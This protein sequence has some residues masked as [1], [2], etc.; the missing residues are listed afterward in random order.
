MIKFQDVTIADKDT[1]QSFTLHGELQNCDLSIANIISWRFLYNTQWAIVNNYLVFRFY[2]N[3]HLAYMLPVPRPTENEDGKLSVK[4]CDA[5]SI[6]VIKALKEDANAL[7]HPFLMLGVCNCMVDV[8]EQFM[9]NTFEMKPN[10]DYADYIYTREKLALLSGKK[11]HGKRN[12]INKFKLLYPHYEYKPLTKDL[13]PECLKLEEKWREAS[14]NDGSNPEL[15]ASE[16][17]SMTRAF[18][19]WDELGLIGGTLWVDNNLIAFTYGCPINQTTFDV[20]VEKADVSYEGAFTMINNEFVRHL[21]EQYFYINREE[22][23]GEEGL[24][25]AKLSYKPDIILEK[26]T[27]MEHHPFVAKDEE[28]HVKN[29]TKELWKEV[30]NDK[31]AF[32]EMYFNRVFSHENNYTIQINK[33]VVGALQAVPYQ[34][35]WHHQTAKTVYISGVS[36]SP[37]MRNLNIGNNIMHQAHFN[38][39][40][41]GAVFA[42]LIPAEE[43][44]YTWYAKCGYVEKIDCVALPFDILNAS[45]TELNAW[46][47]QQS[48]ILLHNDEQWDIAKEDVRIDGSDYSAKD[49]EAKGMIRV[50]N[51]HEA[52]KLYASIYPEEEKVLHI[53]GDRDIPSNNAYYIVKDGK[54][55]KT[56]EPFSNATTIKID[57]LANILVSNDKPIM[58]MMLN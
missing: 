1:I 57:E 23:M 29:E 58:T 27:V 39:Y 56:D 22:D 26:N 5:C 17:R 45:V 20:C 11:L 10:R 3:Q 54:A 13:I 32:V 6:E 51:A 14:I 19:F 42:V 43:W 31:E 53:K 21:P 52:L 49:K 12:H 40:H 2:V 18:E 4:P 8:I 55:I 36:T 46:Q 24:R 9:P 35:K 33:K 15:L 50:I 7:G 28:E 44:L 25:N 34:L 30:F 41:K 37:S 48:T 16:L 47:Q 38:S